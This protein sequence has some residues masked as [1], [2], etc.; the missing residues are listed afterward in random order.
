MWLFAA[1]FLG[2]KKAL[3]CLPPPV[4]AQISAV[5]EPGEL[6]HGQFGNDNTSAVTVLPP[7]SLAP[8][9][10][11]GRMCGLERS[12]MKKWCSS[13]VSFEK[14]YL[15]RYSV[16]CHL[17]IIKVTDQFSIFKIFG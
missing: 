14:L 15:N 7:S 16:P 1:S 2:S 12:V 8:V 13:S 9:F 11:L 3:G 5:E 4:D 6:I 10:I 17:H